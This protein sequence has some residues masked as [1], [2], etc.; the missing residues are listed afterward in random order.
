M[1]KKTLAG[2]LAAMLLLTCVSCKKNEESDSLSGLKTET[3]TEIKDD[4]SDKTNSYK[5]NYLS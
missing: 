5:V 1:M 2:L 3:G 4:L